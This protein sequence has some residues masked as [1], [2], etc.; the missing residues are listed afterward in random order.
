MIHPTP[1]AAVL[2]GAAVPLAVA[3]ALAAPS[4]WPFGVAWLAILLAGFGLD[5]LTLLG[6]GRLVAEL[7][8]PKALHVGERETV[9][10]VLRGR[11]LAAVDV[12]LDMEGPALP[13]PGQRVPAGDESVVE[14]PFTVSTTR[15]G[16]V[17]FPQ[18][19]LRS[20]GPLSLAAQTRRQSLDVEI[21]V[22]P[23]VVAVRRQ[24][25]VLSTTDAPLGAKPQYQKG[26]GSEFEA[27]RDYAAGLDRRA[28]DWKHSA[29]HGKLLCKE[30]QTE[31][32][33]HIVLALDTGH[34]MAEPSMEEPS[35][36]AGRMKTASAGAARMEEPVH[37]IAKLDHVCTALLLLS[38]ISL[39]AG[40]RVGLCTF[41]ARIGSYLA[42]SAGLSV[43]ARVQ[44]ALA[45][46]E[47]STA[48]TNFT[49]ALAE[50]GGRLTRRSLIVVATD[51][52]DT[53][54]ADLMV[55]NLGHLASRHLMVFL[56]PANSALAKQFGGDFGNVADIA[57][58]VVAN[59]LLRERRAV[60]ARLRRLGVSCV[61]APVEQLGPELVNRYLAIKAR[62]LI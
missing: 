3:V 7:R 18:V 41:D 4:Y 29:R 9:A 13:L 28:I 45:T 19:W 46:V 43:M 50:L 59:D 1:R 14:L 40:D 61:E 24:A 60:F 8:R 51:F 23:N 6:R 31:R 32:N 37:G 57:R 44:N 38:Y 56:T 35:A 39:K 25:L 2:A 5:A 22:L 58:A 47:Y 62:D 10:L 34:L 53:V 21:V 36:E 55:K 54:T 49:L 33:H 15:R 16:T 26:S 48:E 20:R 12:L 11:R 42:P 17:C 52:V 27:L 30:F